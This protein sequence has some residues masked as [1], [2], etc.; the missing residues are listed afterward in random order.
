MTQV[1]GVKDEVVYFW[2]S[3]NFHQNPFF[4]LDVII[5]TALIYWL[6][7]LIK[8]TRAIRI[9]YGIVILALLFLLGR[10]LN[11]VALN[12]LL[13][14]LMTMLI[15]AIPVVF[16]PELRSA[17]EKLGRANIVSDFKK[18]KRSEI[19]D[20]I[21]EIVEAVKIMSKNRVG[22]LIV[23][24]QKTGLK[25]IIETGTTINAKI[26]KEL[27][28]T[29]F[30]PKSALH[31]GAVIIRGDKIAAAGCT[32]PLTERRFDYNLGTRH[33]AAI[34]LSEQTDA[35]TLV[36]S[37]ET[38]HISI[39]AKGILNHDVDEKKLKELLEELI[40]QGRLINRK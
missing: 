23:I 15:V 21:S 13:K 29:I 20:L 16:Q 37:E 28:L 18:L 11:L 36:V 38:G 12:Y 30:Q 14:A 19:S 6:Y 33:R 26:S 24:I 7:I 2:S 35:I 10:L 32:L 1:L 25:D 5:V 34:G 22:A 4:V 8:E 27:I 39:T 40:Q 17:L 9:L 31:D 3:L